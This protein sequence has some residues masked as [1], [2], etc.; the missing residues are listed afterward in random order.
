[1]WR[2]ILAYILF[3]LGLLTVTFFRHYSGE[4][5]PYPFV[6]WV[7]GVA[8]FW[9]GFL[10]WRFMPHPKELKM[11]R[12]LMQEISNLKANGEKIK[13]DFSICEIKENNFTQKIDSGPKTNELLTFGLERAIEALNAVSDDKS[14]IGGVERNQT[15]I[16]FPYNNI[17][18]DKK[19]Q[20]VSRV[21]SKDKISL[22][23]YLENQKQTILYVD[24][25]NREQY[26]F[27]LDFL[28]V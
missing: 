14:N 22:S 12:Q 24:K 28:N 8:L 21:I 16:I 17:K 2:R 13:V 20:F 6:F 1:M 23:F 4:I 5:I 27:D 11:Q 18:F 25:T 15:V 26:Y 9:T 3:G 10:L 7:I 19:E